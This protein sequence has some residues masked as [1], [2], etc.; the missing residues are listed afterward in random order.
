MKIVWV[1][2]VFGEMN[3]FW[4]CSLKKI[5]IV[6]RV[7]DGWNHVGQFSNSS[8]SFDQSGMENH[9]FFYFSSLNLTWNLIDPGSTAHHEH[10]DGR[11][12]SI[13]LTFL[14]IK[15]LMIKKESKFEWVL[16][17]LWKLVCFLLLLNE[18]F[19]CSIYVKAYTDTV[20]PPIGFQHI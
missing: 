1:F 13:L 11:Y 5:S 4:F 2:F 9:I 12:V 6:V 14:E 17:K 7:N 19:W 3:N 16:W 8:V 20:E 15:I 10:R 18:R